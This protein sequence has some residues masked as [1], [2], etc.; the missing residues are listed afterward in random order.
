MVFRAVLRQ[1]ALVHPNDLLGVFRAVLR[2][3]AL[4]HPNDFWG[5]Y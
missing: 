3:E 1:E 2:Q 5:G 4:V